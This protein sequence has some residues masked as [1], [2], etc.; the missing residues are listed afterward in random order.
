[1]LQEREEVLNIKKT[2]FS[3]PTGKTHIWNSVTMKACKRTSHSPARE[4]TLH[5]GGRSGHVTPPLAEEL[6]HLIATGRRVS[7]L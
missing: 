5:G 4:K 1:M 6:R 7:F 2:V 3:N